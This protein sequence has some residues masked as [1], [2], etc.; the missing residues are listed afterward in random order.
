M[1]FR[2]IIRLST[3]SD[4]GLP[5]SSYGIDALFPGLRETQDEVKFIFL[6]CMVL[7][8]NENGHMLSCWDR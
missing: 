8:F 3:S 2:N 4:E 5:E 6:L 1:P 7:L